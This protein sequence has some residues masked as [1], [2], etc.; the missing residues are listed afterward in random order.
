MAIEIK[1]YVELHGNNPLDAVM[2]GRETKA[3]LVASLALNDG[4]EAAAE[5]YRLTLAQVH[6]A[7]AFHYDNAD[8]IQAAIVEMRNLGEADRTKPS[9]QHLAEIKRR[10]KP[11]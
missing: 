11:S 8:A 10:Q 2:G 7:M 6:S 4:S 5:Q 1:Q 9:S 3:Y